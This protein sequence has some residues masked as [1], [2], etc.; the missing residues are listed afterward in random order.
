MLANGALRPGLAKVW[1]LNMALDVDEP[2][3]NQLSASSAPG[4]RAAKD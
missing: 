1:G 3:M 4:L 2:L